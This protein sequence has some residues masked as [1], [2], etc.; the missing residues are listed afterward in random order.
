MPLD[1][2][3]YSAAT[4]RRRAAAYMR[5]MAD[6]AKRYSIV[7]SSTVWVIQISAA[8]ILRPA[9]CEGYRY[10]TARGYQGGDVARF[11]IVDN[12]IN[13]IIP[14]TKGRPALRECCLRHG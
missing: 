7:R 4:L 9:S 13:K 5:V 11:T 6:R 3:P 8:E 1:L 12:A 2:P 14:S 10:S